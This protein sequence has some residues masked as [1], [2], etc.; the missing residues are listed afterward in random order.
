LRPRSDDRPK[1]SEA[2]VVRDTPNDFELTEGP[3]RD[4]LSGEGFTSFSIA[5][6]TFALV[7][8]AAR[9]AIREGD[10]VRVLCRRP[11]A[12][13]LGEVVVLQRM[14]DGRLRYTG[15]RVGPL[16]AVAGAAL[17]A[18]GVHAGL[19]ELTGILAVPA[20][21]LVY[22]FS[23]QQQHVMRAF[24]MLLK[25][26]SRGSGRA[27]PLDIDIIPGENGSGVDHSILEFTHDAIIIWEMEGRGIVYWNRAAEAMYGFS[28]EYALG[29]VTHDLLKTE[30]SG[31]IGE[32]EE[33]LARY[34]VWIGELRHTRNGGGLVEVEA[35]LSLMSRDHS[36]WLVLEVNRDVTDRKRAEM[37]RAEMQ[38]RL[39]QLTLQNGG[40]RRH[41]Q[42]K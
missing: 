3:I 2:A 7:D 17:F 40:K 21:I 22:V 10:L 8:A 5:N 4:L 19:W 24:H 36:P 33:K 25:Q 31:G 28:R 1:H 6:R 14:D 16:L 41:P 30:L 34:G 39:E 20:A 27:L 13:S 15:A 26:A 38:Q 18:I 23:V 29:K 37:E 35:R 11:H 42:P 9:R 32:L 12:S